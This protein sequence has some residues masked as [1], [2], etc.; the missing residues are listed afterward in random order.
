M[1]F[2]G[3]A[4][5]LSTAAYGMSCSAIRTT[6]SSATPTVPITT[7]RL[8]TPRMRP[9]A[10]SR[11]PNISMTD[12]A[13]DLKEFTSRQTMGFRGIFVSNEPLPERRYDNPMWEESGPSSKSTTSPSMSI[14]SPAGRRRLGPN[15]IVDVSAPCR[16]F[17]TIAE[18]ITGTVFAAGIRNLK[19]ISVE[20]DIG[21]SRIT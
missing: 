3:I 1:D 5:N 2:D 18:M 17:K 16:P 6:H 21:G 9:G 7:G 13:E 11:S 10:C 14:S 12:P 20:N 4:P 15:P 8:T 19:L